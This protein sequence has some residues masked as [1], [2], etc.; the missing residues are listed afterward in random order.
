MDRI[1]NIDITG[2]HNFLFVGEA[3]S[4]K[5]EVA[6]NFARYLLE[7]DDKPV[8]FF[9]MDMTKP[10]FRSRDVMNEIESLGIIFH[11][12]EQFYDAPTLV[13]GVTRLLK[14][15]NCHVVMDIGGNDVGASAI[16]GFAPKVNND[17]TEVYY[18]LNPY[19]PWSDNLDHIDGTL[20]AILRISHIKLEKVK[21]ISNPNIGLTTDAAEVMEGN[22]RMAEM[23]GPYK[24]IEFL[25][26]R[27]ELYEQVKS[28]S[29][30]PV[31]PIHLYL[32]YE[33]NKM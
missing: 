15:E 4:G 22:R 11:H 8:H 23:V 21:M 28:R 17:Y 24:D 5:S 10:L 25:C 31:F 29:N 3:G 30:V 18:V 7:M 16:G 32:T 2:K 20:S 26:V 14:D 19:R 1:L 27:K 12:Q 6:I 33:W 13:G 9:D